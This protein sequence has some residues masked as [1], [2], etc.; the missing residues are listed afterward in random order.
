MV[1]WFRSGRVFA[2]ATSG[3]SARRRFRRL[4]G[5]LRGSA[6][7][8]RPRPPTDPVPMPQTG[9]SGASGLPRRH[10]PQRRTRV[11]RRRDAPRARRCATASTR[12][13]PF[14]QSTGRCPPLA[15]APRRLV[16]ARRGRGRHA[17]REDVPEGE[18]RGDRSSAAEGEA[19][20]AQTEMLAAQRKRP[21]ARPSRWRPGGRRSTPARRRAGPT[22]WRRR[23]RAG[24][25]RRGHPASGPRAAPRPCGRRPRSAR[26]GGPSS[27]S[28][29]RPSRSP[30]G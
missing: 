29:G 28:P 4:L 30:W 11:S 9:T 6:G 19:G 25:R 22:R 21:E 8:A 23:A 13:K 2:V 5:R 17:R 26:T 15:G 10:N 12:L 16:D 27:G 14:Q 7:G 1:S 20:P 24:R 3:P 18:A